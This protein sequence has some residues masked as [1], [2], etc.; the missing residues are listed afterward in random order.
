MLEPRCESP[1]PTISESPNY[2]TEGR[3]E[4]GITLISKLSK[5]HDF[6][7]QMWV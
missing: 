5:L 7:E 4:T 2:L 6:E 3:C 1:C